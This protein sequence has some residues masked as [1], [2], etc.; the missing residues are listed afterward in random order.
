MLAQAVAGALAGCVGCQ[1]GVEMLQKEVKDSLNLLTLATCVFVS[2]EGLI[3]HRMLRV[4]QEIPTRY[5]CINNVYRLTALTTSLNVTMS[6]E[7]H[8]S[9]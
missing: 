4:K 6:T 5:I 2:L 7:T 1:A 9:S 3:F 8:N